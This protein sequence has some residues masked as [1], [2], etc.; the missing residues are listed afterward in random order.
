MTNPINKIRNHYHETVTEL[1]KCTW[2][3]W[4]ELGEST[5]VVVVSGAILSVF[6]FAIDFV[7]KF[8]VKWV[9]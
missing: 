8:V 1:K 3:T 7:V 2:P 9:T 6:V 4:R 5:L